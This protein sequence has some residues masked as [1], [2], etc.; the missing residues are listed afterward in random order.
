MSGVLGIAKKSDCS[1]FSKV[2]ADF[3]AGCNF[4]HLP[5]RELRI[6]HDFSKSGTP[7]QCMKNILIGE[8][9]DLMVVARYLMKN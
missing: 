5:T 2:R 4:S 9:I 6:G 8:S 7:Q 1:S 3:T